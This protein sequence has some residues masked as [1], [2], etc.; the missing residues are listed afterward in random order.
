MNVQIIKKNG[1]PEW[2]VLPY[3]E[4]EI[5]QEAI[6]DAEDIKDIEE[7]FKA[8]K[9]DGEIT[10]PGEV[11]FAIIE[12]VN[13]I[14]VWREY[15]NLKINALAQEIG[16]SSSYLSQIENKKRNPTVDTLKNIAK[17][18]NIEVDMLI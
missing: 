10:I 8:I 9:D 4:Y 17:A 6:E 13:P 7:N 16:I 3:K 14:R 12:G 2:A 5:I 18:L 1:E 15:K 11:T